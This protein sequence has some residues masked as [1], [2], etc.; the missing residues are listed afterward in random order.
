MLC[1][2]HRLSVYF[3]WF[4]T[5]TTYWSYKLGDV[6][7]GQDAT[8]IWIPQLVMVGGTVLLSIAMADHLV[9]L[10]FTREHGIAAESVDT[11]TE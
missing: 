2:R 7:Q 6:S 9:R 1:D 5:K 4:A 10:I 11:H 8:P 3:T